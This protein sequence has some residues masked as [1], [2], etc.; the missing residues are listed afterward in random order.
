MAAV[1]LSLT[2]PRKMVGVFAD[3]NMRHSRL[4][5]HTAWDQSHLCRSLSHTIRTRA[6]GI[7]GAAADDDAEMGGHDVQT[8]R[9]IFSYAMQATISFR[10]RGVT[11][12][13]SAK[14]A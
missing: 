12:R 13:R 14:A 3:K 7:L 2:I 10:L 9:H 8:F 6:A 5:R 4:C 11:L 1:D